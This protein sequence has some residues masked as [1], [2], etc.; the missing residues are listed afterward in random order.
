M[1]QDNMKKV[2]EAIQTSTA[3]NRLSCERAHDIAKSLNIP[4]QEIGKLCDKL[5]IKIGSCQLGC[6]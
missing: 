1:T 5:N 3:N 6:F 2:I 4:L